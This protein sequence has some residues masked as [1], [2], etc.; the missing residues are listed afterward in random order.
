MKLT[1]IS[2]RQNLITIMNVL[3]V[4]VYPVL[5]LYAHNVGQLVL[6]QLFLPLIFS[7]LLSLI[8]FIVWLV[9]L[10]NNLKAGLATVFF[11]VLFWYYGILYMYLSKAVNLQHWHL[12]PI[13]LFI[14][15]HLVYFITK[16]RQ[17]KTLTNLNTIVFLPMLLLVIVNAA[18]II[19]AEFRKY[20]TFRN[21]SE[22]TGPAY[23]A[24]A[25][26][27]HPDIC[28]I[29]LDEYACFTTIKE[30]W[31]YDNSAFSLFLKEKGFFIA[32]GSKVRSDNTL[33]SVPAILNLEYVDKNLT[34]AG[35]Y[36]KYNDNLLF[37]YLDGIGY[38]IIFLDGCGR[39]R[40]TMK[41]K[42]ILHVYYEDDVIDRG[43]KL[44]EFADLVARQSML[45]PFMYIL[46]D[47][48]TNVYYK[49]TNYFFAN[50]NDY[51]MRKEKAGQP[52][53]LFAHINCPHLPYVFDRNG[54][55]SENPTNYWEYKF[56][57]KSVLRKLY[58]EQFIYATKRITGVVNELLKR[59]GNKPVIILLS[60]HGPRDESAGIENKEQ[61]HRVLN[62]VY[63]PDLDY[64]NLY[65]S[66]APVN[67]IRVVLNKYL[68]ENFKMLEDK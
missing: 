23:R 7:L 49:A 32:A 13:L 18:A 1:G 48:N 3:M 67:T 30:E 36:R 43:Y 42:N 63:F 31:G 4:A 28:I 44:N 62:A 21:Q 2:S 50:I 40:H 66:I 59:P 54:N 45:S 35:L 51:L 64:R 53:F 26:K 52:V 60:D 65:D 38:K 24:V 34:D 19:P 33:R 41:L 68:G 57:D 58:L 47:E 37:S 27:D 56:L 16:T 55:F 6:K 25:G 20:K 5:F 39:A 8:I 11:L 12:I 46:E 17:Q 10:K 14:Y 9:I 29:L 15:F 22:E 61:S